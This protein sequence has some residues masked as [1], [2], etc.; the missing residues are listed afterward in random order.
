MLLVPSSY[1]GLSSLLMCD[2]FVGTTVGQTSAG[3][4]IVDIHDLSVSPVGFQF[5]MT[6]S[7]AQ[8]HVCFLLG[9]DRCSHSR[10]AA[11]SLFCTLHTGLCCN[12]KSNFFKDE[13]LCRGFLLAQTKHPQHSFHASPMFAAASSCSQVDHVSERRVSPVQQQLCSGARPTRVLSVSWLS[14]SGSLGQQILLVSICLAH[15]L[16]TSLVMTLTSAI[17]IVT[18]CTS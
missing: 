4:V 1:D 18:T 14:I 7:F 2:G 17:Q 5:S 12:S 9:A 13:S 16:H 3:A 6:P 15:K 8:T 10:Q 11:Q